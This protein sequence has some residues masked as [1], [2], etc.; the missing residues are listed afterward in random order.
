MID[1]AFWK[2]KNVFI[3]GHTGFKGSWLCLW[4]HSLGANITGF[5]LPPPTNPS[6]FHLCGIDS[7]VHS[8][9]GDVRSK[10]S[11]QEALVQAQPEIVIHMAAQPLVRAS[12]DIPCETYEIN[13][14]GT[15]NLLEAVRLATRNG[16]G[17]KAVI[18]VTTDKCYENKEWAWGYREEDVLGGVDP[19]SNS[20]ACSELV[21]MSY[22]NSF[23]HPDDYSAHG[24]GIASARAGNVIGGGDWAT[25]R[26]I[27]DFIRALLG[28]AK[29]KIRN[30][31]A[32]RPWQ[33]VLE[34]IG[35]YLLLAQKLCED[36]KRFS[37]S[38]NFGPREQDAQTVEWIVNQL[39]I[40]WGE[41]AAFEIVPDAKWHEAHYLKLDCSKARSLL[42]WKPKWNLDQALDRIVDWTRAYQQE[43][44]LRALCLTQIEEYGKEDIG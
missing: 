11:L 10:R 44:D 1:K 30:P 34:P 33:H 14:M 41:N 36:G 21:T 39:C 37:Q 17:I 13:V 35:G 27:P 40:K 31:G 3:T 22:R 2:N 25:D 38:W 29:L 18:N 7:F 5:S 20:K 4:L 8:I 43:K 23:F 24:V 26:L 42:R 32:I 15:V 28:G 9:I 16:S 6:L 19:Y 12:Y